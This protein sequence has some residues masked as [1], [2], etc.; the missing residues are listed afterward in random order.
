MAHWDG[1]MRLLGTWCSFSG[2]SGMSAAPMWCLTN[3]KTEWCGSSV[4]AYA[5]SVAVTKQIGRKQVQ[6]ARSQSGSLWGF[7]MTDKTSCGHREG[8]VAVKPHQNRGC[9]K[10]FE[11]AALETA[12][13]HVPLETIFLAP[14][15]YVV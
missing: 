4:A 10:P 5:H 3:E 12:K 1:R 11:T 6:S 9:L 13:R 8:H 2:M 15:L 14:V 7:G